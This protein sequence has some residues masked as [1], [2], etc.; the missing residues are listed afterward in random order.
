MTSVDAHTRHRHASRRSAACRMRVIYKPGPGNVASTFRY[1]LDGE[2][3]PNEPALTYSG[4]FYD[5]CRDLDLDALVLSRGETPDALAEHHIRIEQ[6]PARRLS[7]GGLRFHLRQAAEVGR[8]FAAAVR[9]RADAVIVSNMRDWFMLAPLKLL[10]VRIV[11]TLHGSFWPVGNRS[12]RRRDR[13]VEWLNGWFWQHGVDAT[14]CVS[15]QVECQL[16]ELAPRLSTPV[17]QA[18]AQYLPGTFDRLQPPVHDPPLRILYVGRLTP[19]KGV[20]TLLDLADRLQR[21]RPD[22]FRWEVCGNGP[23]E[24]TLRRE[25]ER[26]GLCAWVN[27]PGR[28]GRAALLQA[29][30]RSHAVIVPTSGRFAEGLNKV[31]IEAVL[32]HRPVITSRLS[33]AVDVLEDAVCEVP[34]EDTDGYAAEI[35]RLLDDP[36]YYHRKVAACETVQGQFYDRRK[37]WGAALARALSSIKPM[38]ARPPRTPRPDLSLSTKDL[39]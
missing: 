11:T 15:N 12:P 23:A 36:A 24:E 3:D 30:E 5:V 29:Y 32:A 25:I 35:T 13:I 6:R 37:G 19:E 16:R 1:W 31:T 38:H 18:R 8:L 26:R 39:T 9:F 2:H 20:F 14:I 4:M 10:R 28:L 22:S 17:L 21:K 7:G 34:P 33:N 27:L